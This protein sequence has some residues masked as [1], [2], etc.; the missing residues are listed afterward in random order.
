M[1]PAAARL[2]PAWLR[3]PRP[4]ARLRL[5]GFYSGLFVLSAACL[6]AIPYLLVRDTGTG[7][8]T[9]DPADHS[10]TYVGPDRQV[11]A[12]VGF[13]APAPGARRTGAHSQSRA[14]VEQLRALAV[15]QHDS[16]LHQL[17]V[18]SG[19]ALAVMAAVS[20][21]LGWVV[22]GRVLR[23]VRTINAA[24]RRVSA[25][26]L[27]QRLALDGPDDEFKELGA[28]LDDL[29]ERLDTSFEAQRR[30]VANASHELRTPLTVERTLLQVALADPDLTLDTLRGVCEK[31]LASGADQE[32]L[33]DALLTLASSERGLEERE[34][35]DLAEIARRSLGEDVLDRARGRGLRVRTDLAAAP[36]VGDPQLALQLVSNLLDNAVRHNR[37]DGLVVLRTGTR[38]GRPFLSVA[39]SGRAVPEAEIGRLL[40]PFQQ[41]GGQRTGHR[42]G[43]GL[44]LAIVAAIAAAHGAALSVRPGADGGLTVE[45]AFDP[46]EP[47]PGRAPSEQP[48]AASGSLPVGARRA[49]PAPR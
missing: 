3:R 30:F 37:D 9:Y 22:A 16:E 2:A 31:L 8:I 46:P 25:R 40:E 28:T 23:P 11:Y 19:V 24:A 13:A 20:V 45:V 7:T 18:Y 14:V 43:H 38:A 5:T 41:L 12:S 32:R 34:P 48:A 36:A 27:H 44:G 47:G 35:F 39:N 1:G 21:L 17:L 33:I 49:P 29:L 10:Y 42:D 26:N 6:L 4:T 15:S